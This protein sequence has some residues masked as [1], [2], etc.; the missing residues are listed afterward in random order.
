MD[1]KM[2]QA[3][4]QCVFYKSYIPEGRGERSIVERWIKD[5][6]AL[7]DIESMRLLAIKLV[8]LYGPKK[9]EEALDNRL[10]QSEKD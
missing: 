5:Y 8:R 6:V 10:E 7:N 4:S 2:R 1:N 3:Y 9:K